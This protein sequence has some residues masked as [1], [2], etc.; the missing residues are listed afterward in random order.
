LNE[1]PISFARIDT[2]EYVEPR[3]TKTGEGHFA[4]DKLDHGE[5]WPQKRTRLLSI[6]GWH[7]AARLDTGVTVQSSHSFDG[8][9]EGARY[10]TISGSAP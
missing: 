6:H 4:F 2:D 3:R 5:L 9:L 8:H 1:R 7:P 10:A